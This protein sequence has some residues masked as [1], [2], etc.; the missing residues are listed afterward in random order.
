HFFSVFS[1]IPTHHSQVCISLY[2]SKPISF[3]PIPFLLTFSLS[4]PLSLSLS[5]SLSVD[6][7]GLSLSQPQSAHGTLGGGSCPGTPEMRRRQEEALR[8][9]AS[10]VTHTHRHIEPLT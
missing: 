5:L 4:L 7:E 2:S 9:L 3:F 8:R 1:P 10:Q 6:G